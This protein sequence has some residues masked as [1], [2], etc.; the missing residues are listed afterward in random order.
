M[1]TQ[2]SMLCYP[3]INCDFHSVGR[4]F[5]CG[6]HLQPTLVW[7]RNFWM[8]RY[9]L[10]AGVTPAQRLT[11]H[12]EIA[13]AMAYS[14][15]SVTGRMM[16]LAVI[17]KWRA[18]SDPIGMLGGTYIPAHAFIKDIHSAGFETHRT[19]QA[20]TTTSRCQELYK[21]VKIVPFM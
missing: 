3:N 1:R 10:S 9:R 15:H 4:S 12:E 21:Y 8:N 2:A 7:K 19:L 14:L 11:A 17:V 16:Q 18:V 6:G 13:I 20:S 5:R